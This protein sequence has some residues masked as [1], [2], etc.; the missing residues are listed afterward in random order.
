[1][2][3]E[4]MKQSKIQV[5]PE[6]DLRVR[7]KGHRILIRPLDADKKTAIQL[8]ETT[9]EADQ[10]A[11]AYGTVLQ[12]GPISWKDLS[13]KTLR[14]IFSGGF[15]EEYQGDAWCEPGDTV[16]YQ[17]YSG[18]RVPDPVTGELRRD[19]VA[20]NDKDIIA[21]VENLDEYQKAYD[22]AKEAYHEQIRAEQEERARNYGN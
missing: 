4:K 17:R 21:V 22:E 3:G 1:M 16:L 14:R 12:V 5:S 2:R 9:K 8:I 10:L 18:A 20:I 15:F 13:Y 19:L 7:I 11:Q 6:K